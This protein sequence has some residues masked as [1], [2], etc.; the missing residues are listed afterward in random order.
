[1]DGTPLA[2]TAALVTGAGRGVG[3]ALAR[4]LAAAGARVA[5]LDR[6][7]AVARAVAAEIGPG[8]AIACA[9]DVFDGD[10]VGDAVERAERELGPIGL[11]VNVAGIE[12][13]GAFAVDATGVFLV[14]RE[15][16]RRMV[17]RR[18]GSIVTV[19]DEPAAGVRFPRARRTPGAAST[20]AQFTRCLGAELAGYGI[21]CDAVPMGRARAEIVRLALAGRLL[22]MR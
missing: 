19:T 10:A 8:R 6:D 5:V 21:R 14:S 1:M 16:A 13:P 17:T 2:G 20:A 3:A 7:A 18:T 22:A 4:T 9:A 12:P 15:V 11:L